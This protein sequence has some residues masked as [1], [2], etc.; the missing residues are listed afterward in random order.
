MRHTVVEARRRQGLEE[1]FSD[2]AADEARSLDQAESAG[3]R[4]DLGF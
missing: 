4:A 3:K 2:E 1:V